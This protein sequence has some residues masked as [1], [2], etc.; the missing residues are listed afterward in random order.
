MSRV[1]TFTVVF[2]ALL[3]CSVTATAHFGAVIPS[4]EIVEQGSD[5]LVTLDVIFLHPMEQQYM[6]MARPVR[7]GVLARGEKTDLLESLTKTS[8][9]E[10]DLWQATY[11]LKRPGDHLFYLEPAPYWEPAEES[12][13]IHYT[14]VAVN[15]FGMESGWD[16]PVGFEV[17]IM[18]LTRPYGLW[19]GNIFTGQVLK[20][21][22]PLAGCK[23]EVEY[24][25]TDKVAIPAAPFITQ[26]VKTDGRG[27]F[28]YAMPR[29][30]WWGFAALTE[31]D[32]TIEK[33]GAQKPVEL[34]GVLWVRTREMQ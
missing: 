19:V 7:F 12:F 31:A 21:G 6:K 3:L 28:S 20:D 27:V 15:G 2:T 8:R 11:R 5:R 32:R 34:G 10:G 25:N 33:D 18:P 14:K 16:A 29:A 17:E 24:L 13:I 23:V 26:V 9:G 22:I 30:G 1:L 4:T